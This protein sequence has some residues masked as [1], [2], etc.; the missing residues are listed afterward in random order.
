MC[1]AEF[2][3]KLDEIINTNGIE[4]TGNGMT[5]TPHKSLPDNFE[6]LKDMFIDSKNKMKNNDMFKMRIIGLT[7]Y[8][9]S[10]Q[11]ELMPKYDDGDLKILQIDY[12][13]F[14]IW[15]ISRGKNTRA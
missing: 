10:A 5:I 2:K 11:E 9:R 7:S 6:K 13:R 14:S 8:F 4:I 15:S 12:E 1:I 3:N